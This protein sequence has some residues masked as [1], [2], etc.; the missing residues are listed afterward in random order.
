[1]TKKQIHPVVDER[2]IETFAY[3][4]MKPS[5]AFKKYANILRT[6]A[7][8]ID[9]DIKINLGILKRLKEDAKNLDDEIVALESEILILEKKK[10]EAVEQGITNY[11]TAKKIVDDRFKEIRLQLGSNKWNVQKMTIKE[12]EQISFDYGIPPE[13]LLYDYPRSTL[14]K[15]LENYRKYS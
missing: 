10:D 5:Q 15:V 13:I 2:D 9:N 6:N 3:F 11:K 12:L 14:C 7:S 8:D 1:M 4:G